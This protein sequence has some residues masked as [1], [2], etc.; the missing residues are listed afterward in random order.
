MAGKME[1]LWVTGQTEREK[2]FRE[3]ICTVGT[4]T[5]AF[6]KTVSVV[7]GAW[8]MAFVKVM[9]VFKGLRKK[10]HDKTWMYAYWERMKKNVYGNMIMGNYFRC[11]FAAAFFY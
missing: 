8:Q 3:V 4:D 9:F 6:E 5:G 11:I 7:F 2:N 1:R 10:V